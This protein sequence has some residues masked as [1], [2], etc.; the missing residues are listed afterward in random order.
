MRKLYLWKKPID[1]LLV[2][3]KKIEKFHFK[4]SEKNPLELDYSSLSPIACS[5]PKKCGVF[6]KISISIVYI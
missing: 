6:Y 3:S 2:A 4:F 5:L 1:F